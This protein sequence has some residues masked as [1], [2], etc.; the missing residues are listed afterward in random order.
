MGYM[1]HHAIIVSSWSKD[2]LEQAHNEASSIFSWVSPIS[3]E[4][5]NCYAAF[6][7]PPDGSKEGWE[8]SNAGDCRRDRF[9]TWLNSQ[10]YEDGSTP[11]GWVE[12][13]FC[14][15]ESIAKVT[16]HSDEPMAEA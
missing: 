1:R 2:L 9:V 11:F 8:E 5:V 13:Q 12:V 4:A 3:P 6:F 14:D 10:R 15:D 7:V 16:R